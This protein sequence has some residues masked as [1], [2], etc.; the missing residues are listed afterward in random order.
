[1]SAYSTPPDESPPPIYTSGGE[2]VPDGSSPRALPQPTD[3]P[4]DPARGDGAATV[5]LPL[6]AIAS[7]GFLDT[8]LGKGLAVGGPS[9]AVFLLG[10]YLGSPSGASLL[11]HTVAPGVTEAQVVKM[12]DAERADTTAALREALREELRAERA[13]TRREQDQA[14]APILQRLD[15]ADRRGERIEAVLEDLRT[16]RR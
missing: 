3:P 1:M 9:L 4:H 6:A 2:D 14:L 15:A 8:V 16:R 13:D 12:V 5:A 11:G 7:R 10:L